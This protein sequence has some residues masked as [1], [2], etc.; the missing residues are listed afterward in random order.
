MEELII[1]PYLLALLFLIVAF[2]YS[3]VGLGGGTSYTALLAVFGASYVVIPTISLTLNVLVTAV[4]S[5]V[6]LRHRHGRLRLIAPF[7]V[8]SLPFAYLGGMLDFSPEQFYVLLVL[9]LAAVAARIFLWKDPRVGVDLRRGQQ[10]ALASG[11]GA[12]IGFVGG[13]V[14]F[15]GGIFM[16]PLAV[17]LG[18]GT[19][20]E[21]AACG[22]VFTSVTSVSGLLARV[23]HHP[24]DWSAVLPLVVAVL[25]GGVVGARMGSR[26]LTPRAMQR[27]MG[28]VVVVAAV[29][30][31]HRMWVG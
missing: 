19:E 30:L 13:S 11:L 8:T 16:V 15:G 1:S 4:G 28:A 3:S 27:V 20:R 7:L 21:A 18:L 29:L 5:W 10:L 24:V 9:T 2:A 25:L 26:R 31:V 6:F 22:A 12:L 17:L 23:Q 14:G